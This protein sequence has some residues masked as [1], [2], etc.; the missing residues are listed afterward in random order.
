MR[1]RQHITR[2]IYYFILLVLRG[3]CST[4][5]VDDGNSMLGIQFI[6]QPYQPCMS[7]PATPGLELARD[8][9]ITSG[10]NQEM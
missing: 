6:T 1:E 7:L 10:L 4:Q 8:L 2:A 9:R 5:L 3:Y